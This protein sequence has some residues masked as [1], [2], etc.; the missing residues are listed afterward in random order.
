[1][2]EIDECVNALLD[3]I[4]ESSIYQNYLQCEKALSETPD[5]KKEVDDYRSVIYRMHQEEDWFDVSERLERQYAELRKKPEVNAYLE[6][7]L[8]L[9]KVIQRVA[10]RICGSLDMQIP[11]M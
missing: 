6:A 9:C 7:E 2:R 11:E 8:D 10:A 4:H 1:M 3:C 5:L